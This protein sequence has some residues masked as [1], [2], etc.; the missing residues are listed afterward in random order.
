[1]RSLGAIGLLLLLLY[2]TIGVPVAVL[3]FDDRFET[4]SPVSQ[5]DEWQVMKIP[6]SLPYTTYWENA[7]DQHGLIQQGESFYNITRQHIENDTLYTLMKTNLPARDR[8]AELANSV[9]QLVDQQT[10]GAKSPLSEALTL[11]KLRIHTYLPPVFGWPSEN[12]PMLNYLPAPLTQVIYG[13]YPQTGRLLSPPPE[14]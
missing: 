10:E 3:C 6:L 7:A 12:Y 4:A 2:H 13:H 14:H 11:L 5:Q 9:Q 8:F 1:M